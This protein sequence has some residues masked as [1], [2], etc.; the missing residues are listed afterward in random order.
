[1]QRLLSADQSAAVSVLRLRLKLF[2]CSYNRIQRPAYMCKRTVGVVL[3]IQW[4]FSRFVEPL[5]QGIQ[6]VGWSV[7][8]VFNDG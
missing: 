1:M 2:V 6:F 3:M 4:S 8:C 7:T 5:T